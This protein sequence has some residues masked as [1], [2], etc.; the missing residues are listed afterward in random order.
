MKSV[1]FQMKSNFEMSQIF[2]I[3]VSRRQTSVVV[4]RQSTILENQMKSILTRTTDLQ[5]RKI[6]NSEIFKQEY[7]RKWWNQE[8]S[9]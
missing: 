1:P 5:F 9:S 3:I 4:K 2:L 7:D 8:I 6:F